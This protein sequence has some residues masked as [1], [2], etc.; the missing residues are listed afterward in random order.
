LIRERILR[1]YLFDAGESTKGSISGRA[2]A[3]ASSRGQSKV[4]STA[5]R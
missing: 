3:V 5:H 1:P 4:G 2:S